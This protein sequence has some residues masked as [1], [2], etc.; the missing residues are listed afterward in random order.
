M[1]ARTQLLTAIYGLALASTLA[2]AGETADAIYQ[3]GS[4]LTIDDARPK[5]EAVA[6]KDGKILAVDDQVKTETHGQDL[7]SQ[8]ERLGVARK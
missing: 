6:V 8:L 3:N 5:A 4:I 1:N 7:A 2:V